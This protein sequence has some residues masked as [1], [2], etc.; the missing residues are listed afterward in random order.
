[1][2]LVYPFD[3]KVPTKSGAIA[4]GLFLLKIPLMRK[5]CLLFFVYF[6]ITACD[7][8][9]NAAPPDNGHKTPGVKASFNIET[10]Q[11]EGYTAD[12][13][14]PTVPH[15]E[16]AYPIIYFNDGDNFRTTIGTLASAKWE[17]EGSQEPFIMVGLYADGIRRTS[18]YT[19][20]HDEWIK[21]NWGN[22]TPGASSYSQD[23]VES[24]IPAI[25]ENYLADPERRAIMGF[26]LGGLH[27]AWIAIKYP[28][29]F[30]FAGSVSPSFWVADY[31]IFH[32]PDAQIQHTS[33]YFDQGTGE[34]NNYVPFIASLQEAGLV[35]GQDIFYYEVP[36]AKHVEMDWSQRIAIPL[37]L[38]LQGAASGSSTYHVEVECIRSQNPAVG[39][40]QRINPIITFSDGVK[41]SLSTSADFSIVEGDGE[42]LN[43]GRFKVSGASMTIEVRHN[44]WVEKLEIS[45]CQ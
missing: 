16:N 42:I 12:I 32:E 27:A 4:G 31:A 40:Y 3:K 43:D 8:N 36:G 30:S 14:V 35:Y 25:E 41:Y 24:I 26:S 45:N 10:L 9:E 11:I 22:Y 23:L 20:Y 5:A 34:W 38:F 44:N 37:K 6:F 18:R 19:P 39:F 29:V 1:M 2:R 21:E 7:G 17:G 15:P 28:G 13:Y 33:F